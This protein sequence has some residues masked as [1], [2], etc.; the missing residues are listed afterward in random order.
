MSPSWP[1]T[2]LV[3]SNS[4]VCRNVTNTRRFKSSGMWCYVDGYAAPKISNAL[5]SFEITGSTYSTTQH[6][7]LE[8]LDRQQHCCADLTSCRQTNI[9]QSNHLTFKWPPF[10]YA[11]A[12]YCI[13]SRTNVCTCK[14]TYCNAGKI[15]LSL[16]MLAYKVHYWP[17]AL[18]QLCLGLHR[19]Q[20]R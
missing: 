4:Y 19:Y 8:D 18:L 16:Y 12:E 7:T 6:H 9:Y 17:S 15:C 11:N 3:F 13:D 1:L 5:C 10:S 14:H 20:R 2:L